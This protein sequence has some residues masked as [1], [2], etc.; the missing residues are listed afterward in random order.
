MWQTMYICL[1]K[2]SHK[3]I[4][5][6]VPVVC[7]VLSDITE[8]RS[9]PEVSK[10]NQQGDDQLQVFQVTQILL[11]ERPYPLFHPDLLLIHIII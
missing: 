4:Q 11:Q 9:E 7:P 1:G 8:G 5:F 10:E 6:Y 3:G 2:F